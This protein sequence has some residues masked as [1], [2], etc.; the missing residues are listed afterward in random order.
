MIEGVAAVPENQYTST[1]YSLIKDEEYAEAI[2]IL[3]Y[4]LQ[5]FPRSRAALSLLG[6]CHY[7][8]NDYQRAANAYEKLSKICPTM[9]EYKIYH[10]Q[11][12]F[13]AGAYAA[14]DRA[15]TNS[16]LLVT[17]NN[18][19]NNNNTTMTNSHAQKTAFRR[20]VSLLRANVQY[21]RNE[22]A[23]CR[24][25]LESCVVLGSR[26]GGGGDDDDDNDDP[27]TSIAVA[28]V[29]FKEEKF[30]DAL[31][32]YRGVA[33]SGWYRPDVTYN[34]ALCHYVLEEYEEAL[35]VV[36]EVIDEGLRK[37]PELCLSSTGGGG[38]GGVIG[39]DLLVV[40]QSVGS[41]L[42]LQETYLVE[43]FNLK[44]AIAYSKSSSDSSSSSG[45]ND[46]WEEAKSCLKEMPARNEEE[47]DPVTLHNQALMNMDEEPTSGFRKLNFL[48]SNP[49][50]P[51][52]TFGNLLL[53]YCRYGYHDLAADI[54]AENSHLTYH[55]L[56]QDL[57]DY[58]DAE[59]MT[60]T[61]P[62]EAHRKFDA[63]TRSYF[64]R[65]RKLAKS[66]SDA[67]NNNTSSSTPRQKDDVRTLLKEFEAEVSERYIPVLMSQAK[68][69]WE[70]KNYATVERLFR[71]SAEFGADRR[72]WKLNLAHAFF[73]QEE[74]SKFK[75]AIRY[76]HP[77]VTETERRGGSVLDVPA[78]VLAN[79][80][81]AFI[82]TNR[83][84]EA[85]DIMRQIE[86]Q[87]EMT[88]SS[89]SSSRSS[90]SSDGHKRAFHSCIVNLVIGTLYCEKGNF[91]FGISRIIK[92]LQPYEQKL[93]AD[94][95][96]YT[97][98][99]LLA[100]AD[101][102]AKRMLTVKDATLLEILEFL[103]LVERHGGKV[104]SV[105]SS[106]L[107]EETTGGDGV[108]MDGEAR[109]GKD[110]CKTVAYEARLFRQLFMNLGG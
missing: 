58:L 9:D 94:T 27:E 102:V 81:V 60:T 109:G 103:E 65:L 7:H 76:Y 85:E 38:G 2:R 31:E 71:R 15:I 89:M 43:A 82:M 32:M 69:H 16:K 83:N 13:K 19:N 21:E 22:L 52:E 36:T 106:L 100:L 108:V 57:Y 48:L 26:G 63:L 59:I 53:L 73:M 45:N 3:E 67:N 42:A 54:L 14:S 105:V 84:E 28:A 18:N 62:E 5:N 55:F 50:F 56:S 47:I 49:P 29:L 6:Y 91:E 97:K 104:P 51:K 78:I 88:S 80:C 93:N 90:S 37:H 39:G 86:K 34:I 101:D 12:L 8:N 75:D 11:S 40:T 33:R 24:N 68:L 66:I 107:V 72:V 79:L 25:T 20:R 35:K 46:S 77:L 110:R 44:A 41:S 99:C 17:N 87:E 64:D 10:A 92:S 70:R 1:I 30:R 4:E 95:W 61:S 98:R 96:F 74:G 23:A